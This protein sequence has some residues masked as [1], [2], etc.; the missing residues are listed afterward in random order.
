MRETYFS[1]DKTLLCHDDLY[2]SSCQFHVHLFNWQ[3]FIWSHIIRPQ[4]NHY[5]LDTIM[6]S[7]ANWPVWSISVDRIWLAGNR[8]S[9]WSGHFGPAYSGPKWPTDVSNFTWPLWS[10]VMDQSGRSILFSSVHLAT[11]VQA[12]GSKWPKEVHHNITSSEI[13]AYSGWKFAF[14]DGKRRNSTWPLWS[15]HRER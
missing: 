10:I 3:P 6:R 5:M 1:S 9:E 12:Y 11:L 4:F 13:L 2:Q 8:I 15:T 7:R 14:L